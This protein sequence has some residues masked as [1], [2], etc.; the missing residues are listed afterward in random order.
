V[1]THDE[2]RNFRLNKLLSYSDADS[3]N[4]AWGHRNTLHCQMFIV[5]DLIFP[6]KKC[7]TEHSYTILQDYA[8]DCKNP[9]VK[10]EFSLELVSSS[11]KKNYDTSTT[12][13]RGYI[14][15]I[16]KREHVGMKEN[17]FKHG[18][19]KIAEPTLFLPRFEGYEKGSELCFTRMVDVEKVDMIETKITKT[20]MRMFRKHS[21][22]REYFIGEYSDMIREIE[23][24]I[25]ET[26]C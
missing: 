3:Y 19:T 9:R 7:Y 23:K 1:K 24:I 8:K 21:D 11:K 15:L 5:N 22:G 2:A 6:Q 16:R 20:F 13:T 17:V 26:E 10:E 4:I 25:N 12:K 14:Y 18:K